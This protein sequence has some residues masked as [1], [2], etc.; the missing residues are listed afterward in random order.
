[1]S[2]RAGAQDALTGSRAPASWRHHVPGAVVLTIGIALS[3]A[4]FGL[5]RSRAR[6]AQQAAFERR[7]S[8]AAHALQTSLDLSLE[9]LRTLPS[10][11]E[12]SSEVTR[13]EFRAFVRDGL[14]RHSSIFAF[15]WAKRV[16]AA[17]RPAFER[18]ARAEGYPDFQITE[19]DEQRRMVRAPDR[20]EY[21][22]C[23]YIEP[24]I[25][26]SF[27]Y[28]EASE[29][30]RATTAG[31]ARDSGLAVVSP[32]LRLIIDNPNVASV[33]V[34]VPVYGSGRTPTTVDER[35]Q[36]L[37]GFGVELFRVAPLI[38]R[39]QKTDDFAGM[40]MGLLD[41]TDGNDE[42]VLYETEAGV[43]HA[44]APA[45]HALL[46]RATF[47]FAG[48][49]WALVASS[50]MPSP[51][52]SGIVLTAG[53]L[54][55]VLLAG[56]VTALNTI[57]RLRRRIGA[58][59]K[60]GP[61]TLEEKLG[62]GGMGVVYRATHAMLRRPAAIKLLLKGRTGDRDLAR[63]ER[64]VQLTSR[65]AHPNTISI[66]DYGRTADGVF[67]YVME[68]LDG[69]DL[70]RL[71]DE[72][73]PLPP[74]RVIRIL[75]QASGALSEAHALGLIHRD[76]KPANIVL[77]ERVD[78]P[79]IVKVVDFGLVKTLETSPGD[80]SLT[81]VNAITG[82]PLYLAPEAIASPDS[83]D[84]RSDLYALGAVGYFLIT[85]QHVFDAATVVE[86]CSKHLLEAPVPP[87][88][89]LGRAVPPDLEALILACLAKRREDRPAS[90]QAMQ[91]ALL[92][93]ADAG[94]YDVAAARAWWTDRG[95]TLRARSKEK[96]PGAHGAT[97]A[98]DLRGRGAG[99]RR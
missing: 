25:P 57:I 80:A 71:V 89:R 84:A 48:R 82:T 43:A 58:A 88:Q 28:D 16:F 41:A 62:E 96:R 20:A 68:Y 66:F 93:C 12:A 17:E 6:Q 51:P 34:F 90:A 63:F 67:Y 52:G 79:D 77:T 22:P 54:L 60:L 94:K 10:L 36:T 14:T 40:A 70:E 65:L 50:P 21:L 95:A 5:V 29:I 74:A 32:R 8:R 83:V 30:R 49:T 33:I 31:R 26:L 53:V 45:P 11:F 78:E 3:A 76:I 15:I 19:S 81:N 59:L 46:S 47:P 75:A 24:P 87:S 7:A 42:A 23:L 38:E 92:A 18:A 4:A 35:R 56:I 55:S 86:V 27:G 69:L 85:G 72:D 73:G 13:Q 97:M 39:L 9:D 91:A 2:T 1:V 98:I 44:R 61:Y 99:D 37:R 64:E